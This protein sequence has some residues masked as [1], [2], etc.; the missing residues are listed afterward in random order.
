MDDIKPKNRRKQKEE[1]KK[2]IKERKFQLKLKKKNPNQKVKPREQVL[3]TDSLS[4]LN[5]TEKINLIGEL[6]NEIISNPENNINIFSELFILCCDDNVLVLSSVL[7][8]LCLIFVDILPMDKIRLP[9][10]KEA[11]MSI[12]KEVSKLQ[13]YEQNLLQYYSKYLDILDN[14]MKLKRKKLQKDPSNGKTQTTI[15]PLDDLVTKFKEIAINCYSKLLL[16][17]PQMN[18][19]PKLLSKI[20]QKTTSFSSKMQEKCLKT[21]KKQLENSDSDLLPLKL[22]TIKSMSKLLQHTKKERLNSKVLSILLSSAQEV[23]KMCSGSKKGGEAEGEEG[24]GEAET[25]KLKKELK[26]AKKGGAKTKQTVKELQIK[27]KGLKET[28]MSTHAGVNANVRRSIIQQVIALYFHLIQNAHNSLYAHL[29]P[30]AFNHIPTFAAL[31]DI[32]IVWDLVHLIRQYIASSFQNQPQ[33]NI[34]NLLSALLAVLQI[35]NGPASVFDIDPREFIHFLYRLLSQI[36]TQMSSF[37]MNNF[38]KIIECISLLF[39]QKREFSIELVCSFVK[40]LCLIAIHILGSKYVFGIIFT[41][42][43]ILNKYPQTH[44]L[45]ES[46]E[47]SERECFNYNINDPQLTNASNSNILRELQFL[48][49]R[50]KHLPLFK[51]LILS[52][53]KK[54]KIPQSIGLYSAVEMANKIIVNKEN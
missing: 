11:K 39:L 18:F 25:R 7:K 51:E 6:G 35:V 31:L 26:Q 17:R 54:S 5:V 46:D 10:E 13:S 32:Q 15:E 49:L 1:R 9:T 2:Q 52:I 44:R 29:I 12:S 36:L 23:C 50:F 37:Q 43:H 42:K 41:I 16:K 38:P 8:T 22:E 45:L 21:L 33:I 24:K 47:V 3:T 4:L 34:S 40:K 14:F 28:T 20:I 30:T 48:Y 53:V 19:T 27:M